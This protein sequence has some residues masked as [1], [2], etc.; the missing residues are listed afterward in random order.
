MIYCMHAYLSPVDINFEINSVTF[1]EWV[2]SSLS[3]CLSRNS[4]A[5]YM[6][7]DA[8][9]LSPLAVTISILINTIN[10]L[11]R[12]SST[13][14]HVLQPSIG[15]LKRKSWMAPQG[16]KMAYRIR[17]MSKHVDISSAVSFTCFITIWHAIIN[18]SCIIY[19][20]LI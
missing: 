20:H 7:V 15:I 10:L 2:Q 4:F 13:M 9:L 11:G 5:I 18:Y 12:V 3:V 19:H 8:W 16:P 14:K 17:E 6:Y 1:I